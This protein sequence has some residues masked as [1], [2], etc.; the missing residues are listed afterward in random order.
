MSLILNESNN[1]NN[2]TKA[3]QSNNQLVNNA[4]LTQ[5]ST[6]YNNNNNI[7]QSEDEEESRENVIKL[8][9]GALNY[10]SLQSD[11]KS[12]FE[13]F[14]KVIDCTLMTDKDT[15]K[16]KCFAFVIIEDI[17]NNA[18]ERIV[19]RKHEI[20]GKIVDVKIALEGK[21]KE[22]MLDSKKKVFVGGLDP[23]VTS[24]DLKEYFMG[25]GQVKEAKVM[26]DN[27]R[28]VSRC[29]GFVYFENKETVDK[30]VKIHH[31]AIKGKTIEVKYSVPKNQQ[32]TKN[33]VSQSGVD[34]YLNQGLKNKN[35]L[36]N[37]R[38]N[39]Y[40]NNYNLSKQ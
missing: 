3:L 4:S 34:F 37:K 6:N 22:E 32:K 38:Y 8:F 12:Y 19:N 15:N 21:E 7:K 24:N 23:G 13:V 25:F 16:S 20:N 18:K 1:L 10:I 2:N 33:V 30:L 36:K 26:Y 31:F 40:D 28:G 9:V 29:F 35:F 14:G 27:D 39:N 11:I 5:N 17:K